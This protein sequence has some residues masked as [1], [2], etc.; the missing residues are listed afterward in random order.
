METKGIELNGETVFL[1]DVAESIF[2]KATSKFSETFDEANLT[3]DS[4]DTLGLSF[5]EAKSNASECQQL[6]ANVKQIVN[7]AYS[8]IF[9]IS[10][11][12][13]E[14]ND[15]EFPDDVAN[16]IINLKWEKI[17]KNM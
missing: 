17:Y 7:E 16:I 8:D 1:D 11:E 13:Q 10:I 2:Y 5:T 15:D 3:T 14:C 6:I 12:R 9:D 4:N